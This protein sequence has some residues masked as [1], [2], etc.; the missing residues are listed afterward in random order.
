[1]TTNGAEGRI[2]A[3][4]PGEEVLA[5]LGYFVLRL[6]RHGRAE[7]ATSHGESGRADVV[8][9]DAE[10]TDAHEAARDDVKQEATYEL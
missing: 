6:G 9:E 4:E 2:G 10:M 7:E 5:R 3:R 8:G 1:M